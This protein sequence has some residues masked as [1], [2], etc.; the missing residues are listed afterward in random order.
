M[1]RRS[2]HALCNTG[3]SVRLKEPRHRGNTR[4]VRDLRGS[5]G[6]RCGGD[7]VKAVSKALCREGPTPTLSADERET[8]IAVRVDTLTGQSSHCETRIRS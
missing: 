1:P 4:A 7:W 3:M 6:A 8:P 2:C 5:T